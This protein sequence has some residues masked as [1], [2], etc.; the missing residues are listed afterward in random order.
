M[1]DLVIRAEIGGWSRDGIVRQATFEEEA[2]E[3]D[4]ATV[5]RQE[6]VGPEVA[7]RALAKAGIG[8]TRSRAAGRQRPHEPEWFAFVEG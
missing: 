8:R 7:A 5:E 1:P 4:P 2:P 3:V 6:S